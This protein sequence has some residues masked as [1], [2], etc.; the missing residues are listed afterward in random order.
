MVGCSSDDLPDNPGAEGG[1][2]TSGYVNIAINLP[3]VG[4]QGSRA[5]QAND[6]FDDGLASEYAVTSAH[7]VLFNSDKEDEAVVS[8]SV[9]TFKDLKPWNEDA[10]IEN[11]TTSA[12][13]GNK[14]RCSPVTLI[15][16]RL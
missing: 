1:E 13:I 3:S 8:V 5:G 15:S 7:L 9:F 10:T 6:N 11:V 4:A 2:S 14:D 12:K 16:E